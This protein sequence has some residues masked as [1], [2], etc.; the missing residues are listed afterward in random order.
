MR[1]VFRRLGATLAL[2]AVLQSARPAPAA[3]QQDQPEVRLLMCALTCLYHAVNGQCA[4]RTNE[5]CV[6][7]YAGCLE[8]CMFAI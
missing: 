7:W 2:L 1:S 6:A 8:G 4:Q 3:T 5:Q